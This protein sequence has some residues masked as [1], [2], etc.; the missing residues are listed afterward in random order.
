MG[1]AFVSALL[2]GGATKVYATVRNNTKMCELDELVKSWGGKVV[3]VVLDVADAKALEALRG[4]YT[5]IDLIINNAGASHSTDGGDSLE[6]DPEKAGKEMEV[7]YFGPMRVAQALAS[8]LRRSSTSR[9]KKEDTGTAGSVCMCSAALVNVASILS[10]RNVW[11][12]GYG[13]SKAALHY[14]T[15]AQRRDLADYGTLV[16]G[17]YPGAIDTDMNAKYAFKKHAPA[18]VAR[19]LMVALG[20]GTEHLFPDPYSKKWINDYLEQT[21]TA[22]KQE[23]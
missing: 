3:P 16:M 11:A 6:L 5:D 14:F 2:Q 23:M 4:Q 13:S 20:E 12:A 17:V 15:E 1:R 22:L 21:N 9:K 10:F 19:E 7:N 18:S 8:N